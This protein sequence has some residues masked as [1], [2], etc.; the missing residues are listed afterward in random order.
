MALRAKT[1]NVFPQLGVAAANRGIFATVLLESWTVS[2]NPTAK[3]TLALEQSALATASAPTRP[4][5]VHAITDMIRKPLAKLALRDTSAKIAIRAPDPQAPARMCALATVHAT[6]AVPIQAQVLAPVLRDGVQMTALCVQR[7]WARPESATRPSA[8][9]LANTVNARRLISVLARKDGKE[10]RATRLCAFPMTTTAQAVAQTVIVSPPT[11]ALV[12]LGGRVRTA[13]HLSVT[14]SNAQ[15]STEFARHPMRV[16]VPKD[17][18]V[19]HAIRLSA[20]QLVVRTGDAQLPTRAPATE[21]GR[22]TSAIKLS[23]QSELP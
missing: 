9:L 5:S 2:A 17:G 21:D 19:L 23:A 18:K 10:R 8:Q 4:E 16:H 14:R 13:P 11:R 12:R 20:Q 15:R 3:L 22:V 6:A 1:A 7:A